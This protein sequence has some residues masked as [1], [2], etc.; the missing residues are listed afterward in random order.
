MHQTI[1]DVMTVNPRTL[2]ADASVMDAARE[3][4][5][6][7]IG[8]IVVLDGNRLCGILTDR[9]IVV[10]A[11][12][13]GSDPHR[14]RVGDICSRDLTVV[15]PDESL[16]QAVRLMRE[17]A[18]RRLPVEDRGHVVGIV[19]IGDLAID[20]DRWS[21]LADISAAPPNE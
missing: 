8:D 2:G 10:R 9:D 1:R 7:G 13:D 5:E 14:T 20:A 12:A 17:K 18:I 21:A 4:R 15:S 6:H 16:G 19:S 11:L 3:M